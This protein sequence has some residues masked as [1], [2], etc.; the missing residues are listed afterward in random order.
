MSKILIT[1]QYMENYGTP[2][3]PYWKYKGGEEYFIE[4][5]GIFVDDEFAAKKAMMVVDGIRDRIEY[6]E[7]MCREYILDVSVVEDDYMTDFEKSQLE[8]DGE[9]RYPAKVIKLEEFV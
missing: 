7:A 2:S 5:A 9:I 8:F 1:T 6:D 3:D 4:D